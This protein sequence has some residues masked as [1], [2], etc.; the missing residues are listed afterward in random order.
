MNL[1]LYL[2]S[3]VFDNLLVGEVRFISNEKPLHAINRIALD[4]SQPCLDVRE[5]F[6]NLLR[7][8]KSKINP[9]ALTSIGDVVN[10]DNAVRT[11]I[12]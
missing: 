9:R 4:L 5:R 7:N 2:R 1:S 11:T 10:D 12:V 6:L 3:G 8:N